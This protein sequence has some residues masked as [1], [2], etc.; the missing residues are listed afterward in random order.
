M[1]LVFWGIHG[2]TEVVLLGKLGG[3]EVEKHEIHIPHLEMIPNDL[4]SID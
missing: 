2:A 3:N 4:H 1:R